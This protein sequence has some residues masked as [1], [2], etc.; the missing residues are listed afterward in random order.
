VADLPGPN[1]HFQ[2]TTI[3]ELQSDLDVWVTEYNGKRPH[4]GRQCYGKT[5]M[6]T[7]LDRTAHCEGEIADAGYKSSSDTYHDE[8][9]SVS[10]SAILYT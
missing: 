7:F 4:Q 3:D 6:Q 1:F 5:P 10:S 8:G 2:A 9:P